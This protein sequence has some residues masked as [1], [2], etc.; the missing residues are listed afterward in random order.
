MCAFVDMK[1]LLGVRSGDDK[2]IPDKFF[3]LRV[4]ERKFRSCIVLDSPSEIVQI[5]DIGQFRFDFVRRHLWLDL[6][7]QR[8]RNR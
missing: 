3:L 1:E 7:L 6:S 2:R 5:N 4:R 8:Q